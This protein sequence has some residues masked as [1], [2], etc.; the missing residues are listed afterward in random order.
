MPVISKFDS[1][2][3][4]FEA[5]NT[6]YHQLTYIWEC[7]HGPTPVLMLCS[8]L[9]DPGAFSRTIIYGI[10]YILTL[11]CGMLLFGK[12]IVSSLV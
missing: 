11:L 5:Q 1:L 6:V 3:L 8:Y 9:I 12:V 2:C 7:F 4:S 10:E